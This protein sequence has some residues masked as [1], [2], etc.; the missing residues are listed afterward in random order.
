MNKTLQKF[1]RYLTTCFYKFSRF[2]TVEKHAVIPQGSIPSFVRTKDTL[3][4][5]ELYEFF[6]QTDAHG[7]VCVQ[8][9]AA[10]N[11]H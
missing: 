8:F 1:L 5:F 4:P 11:S 6:N 9:L 10:L 2:P 7:L 3:S